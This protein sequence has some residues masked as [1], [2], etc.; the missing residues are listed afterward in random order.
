[1]YISNID[2][3]IILEFNSLDLDSISQFIKNSLNLP[4]KTKLVLFQSD[5]KT[6]GTLQYSYQIDPNRII[7]FM[8]EDI[9]FKESNRCVIS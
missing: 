7:Y 6:K 2:Q 8:I 9:I 5:R 4:N 1:M 3:S